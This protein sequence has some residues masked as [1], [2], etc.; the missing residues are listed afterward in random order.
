MQGLEVHHVS[1]VVADLDRALAFYER[2]FGF[3]RLS[4]PP[5]R[6]AGAWLACGALQIHLVENTDGSFR[7]RKTVDNNDW[8]FAFRTNAF[9]AVLERLLAAGFREDAD[10]EAAEKI[11]VLR[12]GLAGFPQLYIRD[13]DNN[14]IEV[15]GAPSAQPPLWQPPS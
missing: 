3:Q 1:V 4:R 15:N 13:P 6:T 7:T 8:H 10:D 14:V 5:F 11:L 9:D 12:Q 2:A